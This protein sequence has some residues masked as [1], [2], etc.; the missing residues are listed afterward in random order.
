[1]KS[2]RQLAI[3]V[4]VTATTAFPQS[5]TVYNFL[6]MDV[7]AR[8]S[9]LAGSFVAMP[10]DPVALFYNPA[11]LPTLDATRA[12]VGYFK[13]L[14]DFNA[15][16]AVVTTK[17]DDI[18]NFGLG[19]TYAN[20]GSFDATDI[21]GNTTGTFS[22]ADLAFTLGYGNT[23]EE[24][25]TYG[26]SVKMITSSIASYG[27]SAIALDAGLM[28]RIPAQNLSIGASV[29]SLGSQLS[30]YA[31]VKEAL[32]VDVTVGASII[33]RGIPLLFNLAF[34]KLNA[35]ASS[36]ITHFRPFTVGGEFTLSRYVQVRVGYNN[37]LRTDLKTGTTAAMAGLSAG[38]G[39][40]ASGYSV[41]Y[42]LSSL[43]KIGTIHRISIATAF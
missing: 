23:I 29:R 6:R 12:G 5:T 41:D 43:G 11:A 40:Q 18:G 16:Y 19:V 31:G 37:E 36:F 26:G 9:A 17:V 14:L 22:A 21:N 33:P 39:V 1:M 25:L 28:Y 32:P 20:Y 30:T 38:F 4:V 27:S 15:G 24:N 8:A 7:G 34:H 13:H 3:L 10:N 2:I 35:K 42:A